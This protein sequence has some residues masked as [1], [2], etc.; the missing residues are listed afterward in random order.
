MPWMTQTDWLK[1]E[2][3]CLRSR[4]IIC[5]PSWRESRQ[6]NRCLR[7]IWTREGDT[8]CFVDE[9]VD[10]DYEWYVGCYGCGR[11]SL[12]YKMK[13]LTLWQAIWEK[14]YTRAISMIIICY[15]DL[16]TPSVPVMML[17]YNFNSQAQGTYANVNSS[18]SKNFAR[19][20]WIETRGFRF[21]LGD[22]YYIACIY[23]P[24]WIQNIPIAYDKL[25]QLG[26][27]SLPVALHEQGPSSSL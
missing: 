24:A 3:R 11:S 10:Q 18:I 13:S 6:K 5:W 12:V 19:Y 7:S 23:N 25:E 20:T 4:R 22:D 26:T 17:L 27:T 21:I 8:G 15:S 1:Q 14:S 2:F 9:S 16:S